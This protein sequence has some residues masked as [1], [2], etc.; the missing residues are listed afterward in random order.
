[1][2]QTCENCKYGPK[3]SHAGC[4]HCSNNYGSSW[5]PKDAPDSDSTIVKG[6]NFT[7][8]VDEQGIIESMW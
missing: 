7:M 4:T 1:M 3:G 2:G 6:K 8:S 5:M